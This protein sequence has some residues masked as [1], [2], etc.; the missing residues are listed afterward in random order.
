MTKKHHQ[1]PL[2]WFKFFEGRNLERCP[3]VTLKLPFRLLCQAFCIHSNVSFQNSNKILH[4]D[5]TYLKNQEWSLF[6]CHM[7]WEKNNAILTCCNFTSKFRC[8][9]QNWR[10]ISAMC[11]CLLTE[12][13]LS[14]TGCLEQ[15]YCLIQ[16]SHTTAPGHTWC[17]F[18]KSSKNQL[19]M[20]KYIKWAIWMK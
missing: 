6:N 3:W 13:R 20:E 2:Q 1:L 4:R 16:M 15:N 17:L 8:S 12:Y 11:S 14:K 19:V 18:E 5:Q 7:D 10:H 9:I